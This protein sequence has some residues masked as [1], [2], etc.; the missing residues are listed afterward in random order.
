VTRAADTNPA[1]LRVLRYNPRRR[2]VTIVVGD[3]TI[4]VPRR[5]LARLARD[6]MQRDSF[7]CHAARSAADVLGDE[8]CFVPQGGR[9]EIVA[10]QTNG[11]R[12][13]HGD[14]RRGL[15]EIL[16]DIAAAVAR[17]SL[18]FLDDD[19]LVAE[20]ERGDEI[21]A[22]SVDDSASLARARSAVAMGLERHGVDPDSRHTMQL[23]VSEA[24]TNMLMH[25]GGSGTMQL[26]LLDDRLRAVVADRGPGLDFLNWVGPPHGPA[27]AS[28]GYGYKIILDNLEQVLLHTGSEGT[29]LVLDRTFTMGD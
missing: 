5:A 1:T 19:E 2:A 6:A 7:I 28:M 8:V 9:C 29:T 27:Q 3:R 13:H 4:A 21:L 17:G 26:R 11:W 23:C 20:L 14:H 22:C 16:S 15:V 25:G 12:R 18:R 24:T 10:I